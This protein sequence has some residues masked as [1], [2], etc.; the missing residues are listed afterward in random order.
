MVYESVDERQKASIAMLQNGDLD[1]AVRS[2]R[3]SLVEI[4][5]ELSSSEGANHHEKTQGVETQDI[6]TQYSGDA[7]TLI[8]SDALGDC[9]LAESKTTNSCHTLS[10]FYRAFVIGTTR[11]ITTYTSTSQQG[12]DHHTRVTT[13][14][15][16]NM[17]L[18]FHRK[19]LLLAEPRS[20]E[21]LRKAIHFYQLCI[22]MSLLSGPDGAGCMDD[23][24]V[25]Q[26]ASW[27]NMGHVH[28]H[29]FE[30]DD[31][32]RCR[33]LLYQALFED[34]GSSLRLMHGYPYAFFYLFVVG[35]EVRRRGGIRALSPA[36][37]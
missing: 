34:P 3:R 15:L 18:T 32:I 12:I 26:L 5:Q 14:L 30:K 8:L 33:V 22:N 7:S 27:N 28:S 37:V 17:A 10:F 6:D 2:F 11:P 36:E 20:L 16:F 19:G 31:V 4:R 24:Y 23:M 1:Q 21:S 13:A 29:L 35:S 9:K 25:I